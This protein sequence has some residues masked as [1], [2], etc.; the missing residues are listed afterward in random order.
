MKNLTAKA[1]F[2]L[3]S[4][5]AV[6]ISGCRSNQDLII[7]DSSQHN[8]W[9]H[10]NMYND[11]ANF[12]FA[13]IGDITGRRREGVLEDAIVKLNL[14]KPEFV[15]SVGDL[16][17]GYTEDVDKLQAQHDNI[18]GLFNQLD[19]PFFY[20][21]GNHDNTNEVCLEV[22][23]ARHGRTY[24][25]FVY[26]DVLFLCLDTQDPPKSHKTTNVSDEQ[27]A[28]IKKVLSRHKDVRWTCI[29]FH[30]P[31]WIETPSNK[32]VRNVW[33]QIV[34]LLGDRNYTVFSGHYHRYLKEVK[35]GMNHYILSLTGAGGFQKGELIARAEKPAGVEYCNFDHIMWVTMTDEGPLVSNI[36]L[37]G[38]YNDEPCKP[39]ESQY[40]AWYH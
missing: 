2:V 15:M 36:L 26:K 18:D 28:Y 34:N 20:V 40:E 24:Y 31:M 3:L 25:H 9:T 11:P 30:Q 23:L 12:R 10:L 8:P 32:D 22:Y 37:E 14:L 13:I 17:Q 19:M 4:V 35:N 7:D 16:I 39:T 38:I 6:V 33:P 27:L 1:A 21:A 29:F 5:V